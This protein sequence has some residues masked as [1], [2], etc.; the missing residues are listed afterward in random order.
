MTD[1]ETETPDCKTCG[2][3]REVSVKLETWTGPI[4]RALACPDCRD[5]KIRLEDIRDTQLKKV[6]EQITEDHS[7]LARIVRNL[8]IAVLCLTVLFVLKAMSEGKTPDLVAKVT[9]IGEP[10]A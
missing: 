4:L 7:N 10:P 1:T 6:A 5:G 3:K 9:E 2:D 8:G